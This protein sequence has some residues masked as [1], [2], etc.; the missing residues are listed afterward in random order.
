MVVGDCVTMDQFHYANSLRPVIAVEAQGGAD[1]DRL[2]T[3]LA[4]VFLTIVGALAWLLQTRMDIAV[5]VCSL[6]RVEH[7]PLRIHMKRGANRL[8][9]YVQRKPVAIIYR[10]LRLRSNL[11]AWA[12]QRISHRMM[13]TRWC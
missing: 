12:T 5:Y 9:R 2:S 8:V 13:E 4:A 11:F 7:A 3:E 10:Q 1:D 6:Q